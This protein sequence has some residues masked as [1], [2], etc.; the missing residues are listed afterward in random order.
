M[1]MKK[2]NQGYVALVAVNGK[3]IDLVSMG[4]VNWKSIFN[5]TC[6]GYFIT[7]MYINCS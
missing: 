3:F 1:N 4:R 2:G 7:C 5:L 6:I